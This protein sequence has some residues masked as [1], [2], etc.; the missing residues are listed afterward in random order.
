MAKSKRDL[1]KPLADSKFDPADYNNDGHV[2]PSEQKK[3][4]RVQKLKKKGS[5]TLAEKSNRKMDVAKGVVK[6][7]ADVANVAINA[8]SASSKNSGGGMGGF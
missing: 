4:N 6:M 1:T 7:A 2:S 8:R 3:Y 5:E